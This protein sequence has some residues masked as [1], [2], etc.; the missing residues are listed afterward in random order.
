MPRPKSICRNYCQQ[1]DNDSMWRL[2]AEGWPKLSSPPTYRRC[3]SFVIKAA[4]IDM[5]HLLKEDVDWNELKWNQNYDEQIDFRHLWRKLP[6]THT[7]EKIIIP[8]R[9][10]NCFHKNP[11]KN[12]YSHKIHYIWSQCHHPWHRFCLCNPIHASCWWLHIVN[13]GTITECT[14]KTQLR[15]NEILLVLNINFNCQIVLKFCSE[16]G[17]DTAMLWAKFQNDLTIEW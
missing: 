16:H 14:S 1:Y 11:F 10:S 2:I 15:F 3:C 5:Y 7:M 17:S 6:S 8:L 4:G 9:L 12:W 13:E